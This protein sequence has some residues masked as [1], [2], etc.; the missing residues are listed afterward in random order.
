MKNNKKIIYSVLT[1]ISLISVIATISHSSK[2]YKKKQFSRQFVENVAK[3]Q[4]QENLLLDT[5]SNKDKFS[6]NNLI[7]DSIKTQFN[8]Q[9]YDFTIK[10]SLL[11]TY[12]LLYT[13]DAADECVN[14]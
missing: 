5:E 14:V 1:S 11:S 6:N 8:D 9:D 2:I 7:K 13:S 4:E 12:C 3:F 10:L